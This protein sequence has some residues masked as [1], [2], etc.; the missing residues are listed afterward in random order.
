VIALCGLQASSAVVVSYAQSRPAPAAPAA[1]DLAALDRKADPCVDFYQ[2]ACGGWVAR[3]PLP[4]DRRAYGRFTELQER[5]FEILRRT[6]ES[7]APDAAGDVR[8]A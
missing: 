4:S 3:N 8:K 5:N 1:V 2:F 6:L 7:P